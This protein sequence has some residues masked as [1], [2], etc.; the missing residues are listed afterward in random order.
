MIILY[1]E[2]QKASVTLR[3]ALLQQIVHKVTDD[4]SEH[5]P[6]LPDG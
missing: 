3:E 4:V 5:L 6:L 2:I 1:I